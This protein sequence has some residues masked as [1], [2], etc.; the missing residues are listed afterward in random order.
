[1]KLFRLPFLLNLLFWGMNLKAQDSLQFKSGEWVFGKIIEIR[2]NEIQFRKKELPDGP[3][4]VFSKS[5]L[6]N[7]DKSNTQALPIVKR[8]KEKKDLYLIASQRKQEESLL[9]ET[10][11]PP[12]NRLSLDLF[13]TLSG[14]ISLTYERIFKNQR[15]SLLGTCSVSFLNK[16]SYLSF[17]YYT[18]AYHLEIEK[19]NLLSSKG[20]F[21]A[22][23]KSIY[24]GIGIRNHFPKNRK[25]S[26]FIGCR[27]D[28]GSFKYTIQVTEP[29]LYKPP[30]LSQQAYITSIS[31]INNLQSYMVRPS[32][33]L[34]FRTNLF[35]FLMAYLQVEIGYTHLFLEVPETNHLKNNFNWL[36]KGGIG[37][38]FGRKRR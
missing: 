9:N 30:Y 31:S 35:P 23:G 24:V 4:F 17:N 14:R 8:K 11:I 7:F 10:I 26:L 15:T 21:N 18:K 25:T 32:L 13:E 19:E 37:Y 38:M 22:L 12:P 36:P 1:M 6:Q 33:E 34:G 29:P 3:D 5:E 27:L 28:G 2:K 16:E 20:D